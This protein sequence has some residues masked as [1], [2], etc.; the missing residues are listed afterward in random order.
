[1]LATAAILGVP[2]ATA[3]ITRGEPDGAVAITQTHHPE[4]SQTHHHGP[5][6]A[7][8]ITDYDNDASGYA[9][10]DVTSKDT[11]VSSGVRQKA[12]KGWY[13]LGL[14]RQ[15]DRWNQ[16]GCGWVKA[17]KL[18]MLRV[19]YKPGICEARAKI[20]ANRNAIG[21]DFNCKAHACDDGS[22]TTEIK[23]DCK[24]T[25]VIINDAGVVHYIVPLKVDDF[26]YRY[27]TLDGADTW[28]RAVVQDSTSSTL[29]SLW[30]EEPN[31]CVAGNRYG[32]PRLDP[33][34]D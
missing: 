19:R 2:G 7:T 13:V 12:A 21:K 30:V 15:Q 24:P 16:D 33:T 3:D 11:F 28:G 31:A 29:T 22:H 32:G 20:L 4:E 10:G 26:D 1:M 17:S 5:D 25:K 34:K 23:A 8:Y 6:I 9:I 14:V 27:T 18:S